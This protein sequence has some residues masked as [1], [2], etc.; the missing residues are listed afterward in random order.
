[1]TREF[2]IDNASILFLA[3]MRKKYTNVFRFSMTLKEPIQPDVLQKAVDRVYRRFPTIFA[4]FRP[5]FFHYTQFPIQE[6]PQVQPDPGCLITMP[7]RDIRK[8]AY[9]VFYKDNEISIE[10]F[11]ALTDGYGS[12]ASFS[13]LVAEYLRLLHG[14]HIPVEKTLRDVDAQPEDYEVT[15][16]FITNQE[17]A[18][19]LVPSCYAYQIPG[20]GQPEKEI[21]SICHY[22][23]VNDILDAAHRYGVSANTLISAVMASA[24]MEIQEK[25]LPTA[26]HKPVRIM[27]PVDLRRLFSSRTLRNFV[28]YTLPTMKPSERHLPLKALM[29]KFQQ[30]IRD[31]MDKKR[32]SAVMSYNVGTQSVW[33]FKML[34]WFLKAAALRI[35]YRFFGESNSSITVTNLGN[36]KLPDAMQD[37]VTDFTCTLTPRVSSPYGCT[38][39]S[40]NDR[41]CINICSF[42]KNHELNAVFARKMAE[43]LK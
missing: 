17:G 22:Y 36:V 6:P 23:S 29:E 31:Q 24:I 11:H 8:C 32:L 34:P 19:L 28:L 20:V 15:D 41:M 21:C 13:T 7:I 33:Y 3:L 5:G 27:V 26:K 10:A 35:G 30:E 37:Y 9:R 25:H 16:D 38:V 18:P 42:F 14:M 39:L 1:M 12:I 43:V 4:G 40:Y 2:A